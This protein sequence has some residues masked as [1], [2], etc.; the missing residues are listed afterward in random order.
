MGK[1]LT[2]IARDEYGRSRATLIL[3]RKMRWNECLDKSQRIYQIEGCDGCDFGDLK[4][5][6]A[7]PV[8]STIGVIA[9]HYT[10]EAL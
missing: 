3:R 8:G 1:S 5:F 6:L 4:S 9:G 2:L 7:P 10:W